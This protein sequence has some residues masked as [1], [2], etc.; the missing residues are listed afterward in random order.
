MPLHTFRRNGRRPFVRAEP[1]DFEARRAQCQR[2]FMRRLLYRQEKAAA[3]S[4]LLAYTARAADATG[5]VLHYYGLLACSFP[6]ITALLMH[7][8][9]GDMPGHEELRR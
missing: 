2:P 1:D 3:Q 6:F 9:I 7:A 8:T 5:G 4:L